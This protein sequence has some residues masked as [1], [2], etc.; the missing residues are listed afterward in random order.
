M[1]APVS[2]CQSKS[3]SAVSS[4]MGHTRGE[5]GNQLLKQLTD[6]RNVPMVALF[7]TPGLN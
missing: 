5:A 6:C 3:G 4:V 1:A 7:Y 2:K